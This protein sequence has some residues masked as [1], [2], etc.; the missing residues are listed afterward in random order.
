MTPEQRELH[1]SLTDESPELADAYLRTLERGSGQIRNPVTGE[2][3]ACVFPSGTV[4]EE[5]RNRA[6]FRCDCGRAYRYRPDRAHRYQALWREGLVTYYV[7]HAA[8][9][10]PV[11]FLRVLAVLAVYALL[12][13]LVGWFG[14]IAA[15]LLVVASLAGLAL[16]G[17][18]VAE[19]ANQ[20][21]KEGAP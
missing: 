3:H 16:L 2:R 5:L 13:L 11:M 19:W 6:L 21:R 14:A 9:P 10:Q 15:V 8:R 12:F 17:V 1:R 20:P 4:L 7:R 18:G